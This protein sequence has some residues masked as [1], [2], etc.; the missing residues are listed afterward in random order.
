L[1]AALIHRREFLTIAAAFG[2]TAAFGGSFVQEADDVMYVTDRLNMVQPTQMRAYLSRPAAEGTFP[3]IVVI[4]DSRGP[5]E[6]IRAVVR[7]FTESGYMVIAPDWR[8]RF[9]EAQP[10]DEEALARELE[11]IDPGDIVTDINDTI[12]YLGETGRL[13]DDKVGVLGLGWGGRYSMLAATAVARVKAAAVFYA[14]VRS[15]ISLITPTTAPVLGVFAAIDPAINPAIPML[16][17]TLKRNNV[18]HEI[19]VYPGSR[20]EVLARKDCWLQTVGHFD[21]YLKS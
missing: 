7:R 4:H 3:A 10:E 2:V 5:N 13:K 14:D 21:K 18:A 9:L 1:G 20:E 11:K 12:G 15:S 17:N 19:R 6:A 8:S 16:E